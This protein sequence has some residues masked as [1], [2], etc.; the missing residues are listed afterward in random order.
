MQAFLGAGADK[1]LDVNLVREGFGGTDSPGRLERV[2][3]A[4]TILLDP[5]AGS[6]VSTAEIFGPV[7]CVYSYRD[8]DEAIAIANSLPVAFQ[9]SVFAQDIGKFPD[10]N[11]AE[12]FNRIPGVTIS[13]EITGEGLK[14][15]DAVRGSRLRIAFGSV[16]PTVI[17][18]AKAAAGLI[19]Y[20]VEPRHLKMYRHFAERESAFF[21]Q[22]VSPVSRR[23]DPQAQQEAARSIAEIM[24]LAQRFRDAMLRSTMRDLL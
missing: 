13:R 11:I 8:L 1:Q 15:L 7:T 14:T 6:K 20:G 16:G 17:V 21:E 4:P 18:A 10:L 3:S 12:S 22:I 23:R 24:G 2:R 9:A 19:R 5:P